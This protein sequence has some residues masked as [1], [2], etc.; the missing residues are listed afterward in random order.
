L[1]S[2]TLPVELISLNAFFNYDNS[3]VF[4]GPSENED[5]AWFDNGISVQG[6]TATIDAAN[7]CS[8][9]LD[10]ADY[11]WSDGTNS[12]TTSGG[13]LSLEPFDETSETLTVSEYTSGQVQVTVNNIECTT[14][15]VD[16]LSFDATRNERN[17]LLSWQ[18]DNEWNMARYEVERSAFGREFEPIGVVESKGDGFESKFYT[19]LDKEP[20]FGS[21]YYRLR[22]VDADGTVYFS[23]IAH[24]QVSKWSA[25]HNLVVY[26][27]EVRKGSVVNIHTDF[28]IPTTGLDIRIYDMNGRLVVS[29]RML[30]DQHEVFLGH[31]FISG[32][33]QL[34]AIN[35][36][37]M[38]K[39]R[40]VVIE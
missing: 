32:I 13:T 8:V 27:T 39:Q 4:A 3:N 10:N 11:N 15:A 22:M 16:L 23:D 12:S 29:D 30:T 20:L 14:T 36:N 21:N 40:F 17:N 2:E 5:V 7:S 31:S 9:N 38:Y 18:V 33:Y 24:V 6:G 26:P 1:Q 19:F 34:V 37:H 25:D 28:D 35:N